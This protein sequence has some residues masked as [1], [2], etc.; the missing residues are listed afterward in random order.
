MTILQRSFFRS[1][2]LPLMLL[3]CAT[4]ALALFGEN[5]NS[6]LF[7]GNNDLPTPEQAIHVDALPNVGADAI[8]LIFEMVDHVYLYQHAFSF[9]LTDTHGNLLDDFSGFTV[10]DGVLKHDELFGEVQVYYGQLALRL[11]LEAIPLTDTVLEVNY[12][13]CIEDTLCYPPQTSH[14]PLTFVSAEQMSF[15]APAP[16]PAAVPAPAASDD[17]GFFSTLSSQDANAFSRWLGSHNLGMVLLLFYVG[18]LLLALTPCVFPMIPI[19]SG[20]IAGQTDPTARRGF[21]LSSA[22]V[23]GMAVPYTLAG[24]LVALFGAGL[25]LQFWLQQPAA[26]IISA[27]IFL[28]LALGMF[29]VF[30]LQLPAFLRDRLNAASERRQGGS[31]GGA[32]L[33]GAISGLIVSP[34]V[35]PIL[36]GA[37]IYVA[38]S[39]EALTGALTLFILA[40]GMGT[41]LVI[42]GTGG[43]H[44]LPRAGEWM[45]DIKRFFGVVMLGVA[46]WLL[47]RIVSPSLTLGLY[48]VLLAVYGVQLGALDAS[49]HRLRRGIALVLALYGAIMVIGA[50]GGGTD[51][52]QP[53][54]HHQAPAT[55]QGASPVQ[56][57]AGVYGFVDVSGQQALADTLRQARADN[58]PV[59]VDFFAEW[60]V[61]CKV[62]EETT[63]SD[64]AVL[65]AMQ[66]QNML[67]VRADITT[68]DRENQ[69][70]MAEYG[71]F[72][73]PSLVFMD[74]GGEEIPESRILGEMSAERFLRH[75]NTRVFPSI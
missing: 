38:S 52:W 75:L 72:G 54:A 73:L 58:R 37:L 45:D 27:V 51:P 68:I 69:A 56:S 26:I 40:L 31:L 1:L 43:S 29:G 12:Q 8:D 64:A 15:G 36:A 7:G 14:F 4:P 44:L 2:A 49:G 55:T 3:V 23:L 48:G 24:L 71:I 59:L 18:G 32:A 13:G 11:P 66:A 46:I 16:E 70:I 47:G 33:I 21:L 34:C 9:R 61:A 17:S 19:L 74:Q 53:L 5:G 10:P 25:N 50:A 57:T 30:T 6:S 62:L 39:G 41:P 20:I 22:Y 35:T 67:L 60:C 28:L 42:F 63:L 65:T